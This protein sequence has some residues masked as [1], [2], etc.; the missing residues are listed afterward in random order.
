MVVMK[1]TIAILISSFILLFAVNAEAQLAT[2]EYGYEVLLYDDGTWEYIDDS[3]EV[4][5]DGPFGLYELGKEGY[6]V[7]LESMKETD[8][9][10]YKEIIQQCEMFGIDFSVFLSN[11]L[12]I[13]IG[14]Y[15]DGTCSF[16]V[17]SKLED[18]E[19]ETEEYSYSFIDDGSILIMSDD[20]EMNGILSEGYTYLVLTGEEFGFDVVLNRVE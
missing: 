6:E 17:S 12:S 7:M 5:Y 14:L 1:K 9:E 11:I 13:Q 3:Y 19:S 4:Y 16:T 18:G 15:D 2:T 10:G 8:P 20:G